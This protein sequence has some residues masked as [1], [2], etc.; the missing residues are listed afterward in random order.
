MISDD[1]MRDSAAL[2]AQTCHQVFQASASRN[3]NGRLELLSSSLD[4]QSCSSIARDPVSRPHAQPKTDPGAARQWTRAPAVSATS[5]H[6]SANVLP[7]GAMGH[8]PGSHSPVHRDVRCG[9]GLQAVSACDRRE[10]LQ[11]PARPLLTVTV[12]GGVLLQQGLELRY[13]FRMLAGQ[14]LCLVGIGHK[15]I[16]LDLTLRL[17][18][19]QLP[20]ALTHGRRV[21]RLP[22]ERSG[23]R[24]H[25]LAADR[26][27]H[28]GPIPRQVSLGRASGQAAQRGHPIDDVN[29]YIQLPGLE[30]T[31]PVRQGRH[32]DS[33]LVDLALPPA[34]R[35]IVP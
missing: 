8:R 12:L 20:V 29:R 25:S 3:Q 27:P 6:A 21:R 22:V 13:T 4:L 34:E 23:S 32:A 26:G 31:R 5:Q 33:T 19:D 14:I 1:N 11:E 17:R 30:N 35:T 15:I 28:I 18:H 7:S 2:E 9:P 24:G 10:H 16:E